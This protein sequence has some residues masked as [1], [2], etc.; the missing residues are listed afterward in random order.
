MSVGVNV[1]PHFIKAKTPEQLVRKMA[2]IAA[3]RGTHIPFHDIQKQDGQWFAWYNKEMKTNFS[4]EKYNE[5]SK[6]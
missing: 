1:V 6:E 5:L 2:A 3:R 4:K